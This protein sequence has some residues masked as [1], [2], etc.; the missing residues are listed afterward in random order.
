MTEDEQQQSNAQASAFYMATSAA[1]GQEQSKRAVGGALWEWRSRQ[2]RDLDDLSAWESQCRHAIEVHYTM[3]TGLIQAE[4]VESYSADCLR[5]AE[6]YEKLEKEFIAEHSRQHEIIAAQ[7]EAM[8]ASGQ[9]ERI[10]WPS[11]FEAC[12]C[13]GPTR[14]LPFELRQQDNLDLLEDFQR[15]Q[16]CLKPSRYATL[17]QRDLG[18]V[19]VAGLCQGQGQGL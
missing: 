16:E 6:R 18:A 4:D 12:K 5:L 8:T 2:I 3:K 15:C 19:R 13:M 17:G 7:H 10:I 1:S 9:G 11:A 14:M